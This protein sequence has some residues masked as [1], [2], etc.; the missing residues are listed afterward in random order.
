MLWWVA[1]KIFPH[2]QTSTDSMKINV[3]GTLMVSS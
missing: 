2:G 3:V 1:S